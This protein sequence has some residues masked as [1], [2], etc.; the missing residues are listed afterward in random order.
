M[1][2]DEYRGYDAVGLAEL[3]AKGEVRPA[4]LLEVASDRRDQVDPAIN[5]ISLRMDEVG[6]A[7]ADGPF[8]GPF[9]GVPFLLKDL[10]QDFAGYPTGSGTGPLRKVKADNNSTVV[11][12]WIDAG[13]VIFGKTT[14]PEFGAVAV[15]ETRTYGATRNPWNLDHTPGGSSGGSAAAVA[16]GIVPM[17][18]ASDGGGSIRIPAACTG[19]FGLK[20]GRGIIPAGP[21]VAESIFGASTAG[22]LSRS[23][24]DS[25][26]MLDLLSEPDPGGPYL[27]ARPAQPYVTAVDAPPRRLR[28]GFSHESPLGAKVHPEA[29]RAVEAT[30]AL[31]ERLGHDVEPAA[32]R[33]DG[34][35]AAHDFMTVWAASLAA[36]L[37]RA[38]KLTGAKES[39]FDLTTRVVAAAG[40]AH[41]A[42]TLFEAHGRWNTYTRALAEF[43]DT[44]DL[45]LTPTLAAPPLR[46]GQTKP[47]VAVE[48]IMALLLELRAGTAITR[49]PTYRDLVLTNLAP[50][51]F[52]Q[53]ANLTGRPAMSVPLHRTAD[54]LPLGTQ[55]VGPLGSEFLLLRLAAQLEQ[56]QPWRHLE[57][58]ELGD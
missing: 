18:G 52:T 1:R 37:A 35:R 40:R 4:E 48:K 31:L 32:P 55:F 30:A 3:V 2:Y 43:H 24:R 58:P 45:L 9:A 21:D 36:R 7:A 25:A 19:L 11:Q 23:V 12:R 54:G 10:G 50:V 53:L 20:A 46:I 56:A 17:A 27:S 22:V 5:A 42:A 47:P 41:S 38:R 26:V 49:T 13:L 34:R 14:T 29:V 39:D 57:P 28:I 8:E 33:I 15:T 6:R 51:P 16:A 44:Y